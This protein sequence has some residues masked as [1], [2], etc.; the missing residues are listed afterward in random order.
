MVIA[1]RRRQESEQIPFEELSEAHTEKSLAAAV[2][3]SSR[4]SYVALVISIVFGLA[5]TVEK[6]LG[7]AYIL[8][9]GI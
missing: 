6:L 1:Q 8:H 5:Y 2:E 3:K 4:A 9:R 7:I